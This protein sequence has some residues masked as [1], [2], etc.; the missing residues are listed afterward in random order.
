MRIRNVIKEY[1]AH[2]QPAQPSRA[3]QGK[4]EWKQYGDGTYRFKI[5]VRNIT[6]P[7]H[8]KVHVFVDKHHITTLHVMNATAKLD[9]QDNL[10]I[11]LPSIRAEQV[12]PIT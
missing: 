12:S 3:I 7:D 6:L 4:S 11:G 10:S 1:E 5:S 8:S 9:T 2:L